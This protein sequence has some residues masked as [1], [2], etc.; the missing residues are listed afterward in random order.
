MCI[1]IVCGWCAGGH[2]V[3][4]CGWSFRHESVSCLNNSDLG[5]PL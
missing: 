3:C 5:V 1:R 2:G 4:R